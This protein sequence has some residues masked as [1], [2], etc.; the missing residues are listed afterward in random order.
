[1][2]S[3]VYREVA[4]D[5]CKFPVESMDSC[6]LHARNFL[7]A[8]KS[9]LAGMRWVGAIWCWQI[10]LMLLLNVFLCSCIFICLH[11]LLY[12]CSTAVLFLALYLAHVLMFNLFDAFWAFNC[13]G[14]LGLCQET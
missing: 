11:L 13:I 14:L 4:T 7:G 6:W 2:A 5:S 12:A 10:F 3:Q 9:R 8:E 1:M